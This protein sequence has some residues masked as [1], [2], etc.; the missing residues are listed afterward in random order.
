MKPTKLKFGEALERFRSGKPVPMSEETRRLAKEA[1]E[2]REKSTD[3]DPEAWAKR[4][5][6][7]MYGKKK[8]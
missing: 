4:L 7:N 1:L 2:A 8:P 3:E 6:N 5:M